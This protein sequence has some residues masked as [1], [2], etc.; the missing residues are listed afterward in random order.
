LPLWLLRAITRNLPSNSAA[1]TAA[2]V[3]AVAAA[4]AAATADSRQRLPS[5]AS[6][7]CHT[8]FTTD[9]ALLHNPADECHISNQHEATMLLLLLAQPQPQH[10]LQFSEL[11]I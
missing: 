5:S 1:V 10:S 9:Q 2:A 11:P 3:T 7:P 8:A 4:A 6:S